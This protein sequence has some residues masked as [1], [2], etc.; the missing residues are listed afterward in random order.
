MTLRA[1]LFACGEGML[2]DGRWSEIHAYWR[3]DGQTHG[4][5]DGRT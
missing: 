2:A 5:L 4:R 1:Q 3:T